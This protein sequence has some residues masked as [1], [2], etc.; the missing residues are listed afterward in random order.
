LQQLFASIIGQLSGG[1]V[2]YESP[3]FVEAGTVANT[4]AVAQRL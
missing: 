2:D 1:M 4:Q 3:G